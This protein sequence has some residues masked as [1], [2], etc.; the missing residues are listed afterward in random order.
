MF[1]LSCCLPPLIKFLAT[2]LDSPAKSGVA[3][4]HLV[5]SLAQ[6]YVI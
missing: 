6:E 2:S 1:K 5:A 4:P 3:H